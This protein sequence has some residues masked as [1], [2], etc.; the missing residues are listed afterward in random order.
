MY[1]LTD[2]Q[3]DLRDKARHLAETEIRPRAA[4]IDQTEQYPWDNVEKLTE[5]GFMGMTIPQ[6]YGGRVSVT[7]VPCQVLGL[8]G[9]ILRTDK[10]ESGEGHHAWNI[11]EVAAEVRLRDAFNLVDGDLVEVRVP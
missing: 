9:F 7:L 5:A 6:E 1:A 3:V 10:N 8:H 4:E 11:I 2:Q